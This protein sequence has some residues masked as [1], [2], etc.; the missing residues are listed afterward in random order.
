MK[1]SVSSI[2]NYLS[3]KLS[4]DQ[5]VAGFERTEVEVEQILSSN[6]FDKG[7]IA[8][9]INAVKNHPNADRLKLVSV[10]DGKN[11][12]SE[13]VCG[14]PNVAANQTV[15]LAQ[16]GAKLPDGTEIKKAR[17]RGVE[18]AGMLCS[19][20]ELGLSDD[21]S[22]LL[23]LDNSIAPGTILCDIWPEGDQLDIKTQ[24]NRWDQL[25]LI[26]LAREA[27][28]YAGENASQSVKIPASPVLQ[29]KTTE[30]VK[31]KKTGECERFLSV[32]L[33]VKNNV[34]SP[35]WLVDNLEANG[36]RSIS[37]V[38]DITNFVTL[39][40]GQPSHAYDFDKVSG[41]LSV[42]RGS[43]AEKLTTLDGITRQLTADDLVIA[44]ESGAVG[45]AGVIGGQT[46]EVDQSTTKIILEVAN[47]DRELVRKTAL[48]HGLRT[49]ASARFER[50]LPL[51]LPPIALPRLIQLFKEVCQAEI[52]DG[53][54]DQLYGWPWTQHIGL[55][56]RKAERVLGMKID[57]K[58]VINGL[59]R[60]GFEVEH[61][62]LTKEVTRHL[63]RPYI[64]GANFKQHG[65]EAFDC[66]YLTSYIYS[67]IGKRIGETAYA[68]FQSGVMVEEANL[69]PG[70][71]VF[72]S[73]H[74]TDKKLQKERSDIGHVG[75]YMGQ[76]KVIHAAQYEYKNGGWHKLAKPAV[77]ESALSYFTNNP[78]YKGARRYVESFNHILAVT[79]PWW[80]TDV[81]LEEDL[82]EEVI[83]IIG[84]DELPTTTPLL[85]PMATNKYQ[86]LPKILE[87]KKFLVAR[88]L[89]EVMTYSFIGA[90]IIKVADLDKGNHLEILNPL[91]REQQYLRTTLLPSH[92]QVVANNQ[93]YH[94]SYE[95]FEVSRV[96]KP[97]KS[98]DLPDEY[99]QLGLTTYG[100]N[101]LLRLK[102]Q[103]DAIAGICQLEFSFDIS[104]IKQFISGRSAIIKLDG[105]VIGQYGQIKPNVLNELKIASEISYCEVDLE[106]ILETKKLAKIN[107]LLPY[108]PVV[109]DIAIEVDKN[110]FWQDIKRALLKNSFV[111]KADFLNDFQDQKLRAAK[112]KSMAFRVVMDVGS[113]PK[114]ESISKNIDT[115]I[116]NLKKINSLKN[117]I[118]R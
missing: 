13:I 69:K 54:F 87:T 33:T 47:F 88:G 77:V 102:G 70:D 72:R 60:L 114:S 6:K 63:G 67:L 105:K 15:V 95:F 7:I 62:S 28:G 41:Q 46:T 3:K 111:L 80:R 1:V 106:L 116:R 12:H 21:H 2:N 50:S 5:M 4:T 74:W 113:Q 9:K 52:I 31:V 101:S 16:V 58:Q 57:E 103:I 20:A 110:V 18:S 75:I 78:G 39:E 98:G 92:L 118:G 37:P 14:A 40:T 99:W 107:D 35:Q 64:W 19:P 112:R 96:Y 25:S 83:K 82:I 26:G 79:S 32:K 108:S 29:Y 22:G 71:L 30:Y 8:A 66:S 53:P 38:V 59:K 109:R 93:N 34:A 49:E 76:N 117:L 17:I 11:K 100:S 97:K 85:P 84:Y 55:R 90:D 43:P 65:V 44:D 89:F 10:D 27:S 73:G 91:S 51:S 61:F 86:V 104:D 68:Q 115:I 23:L 42:R 94:D 56:L 24:P 36:L 81:T 48:R 45:L